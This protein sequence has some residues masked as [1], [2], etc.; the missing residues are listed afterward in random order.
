MATQNKPRTK[1]NPV[2]DPSELADLIHTPAVGSG[3]SSHLL[4]PVES[5]DLTTV[6]M[7]PTASQVYPS[8]GSAAHL[9]TGAKPTTGAKTTTVDTSPAG[10]P[11]H[12]STTPAINVPTEDKM[13]TV[14]KLITVPQTPTPQGTAAHLP[15]GAKSTTAAKM[16][17]VDM[18]PAGIPTHPLPPPVVNMPTAAKT[19]TVDK[20]TTV[21]MPDQIENWVSEDGLF[22]SPA[23]VR[24]IRFPQDALS[25]AEQSVYYLLWQGLSRE[26]EE[27]PAEAGRPRLAQAGYDALGRGTGFS[28]KTI[29][30]IIEKLIEKGFVAIETPADIYRRTSTTYRVFPF[31]DVRRRQLEKRRSYVARIGPGVVYAH[32]AGQ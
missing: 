24:P 15:T 29:Q 14:G 13:P 7:S 21:P 9:P 31:A 17:T 27:S 1:N 28:K 16:T 20:L 11:T 6:V 19:T 10:I 23:K 32:R 2:F 4:R 25:H 8:P 30:R 5:P 3:V 12:P 26:G 22:I 18:S